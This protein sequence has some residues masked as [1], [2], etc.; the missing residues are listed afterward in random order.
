VHWHP[1][2]FSY[3]W[4]Y[5]SCL[6]RIQSAIG[7][8]FLCNSVSR[9]SVHKTPLLLNRFLLFT[10]NSIEAVDHMNRPVTVDIINSCSIVARVSGTIERCWNVRLGR[11]RGLSGCRVGSVGSVVPKHPPQHLYI[12]TGC[13]FRITEDLNQFYWFISYPIFYFSIVQCW[14]WPL[15][16]NKR[17]HYV[18][19]CAPGSRQSSLLENGNLDI[20]Y[21]HF[22]KIFHKV[23]QKI[24]RFPNNASTGR[25]STQ[26]HDKP[27]FS[28]PS[29]NMDSDADTT[30]I[31]WI[32]P[33]GGLEKT[34]V[35]LVGIRRGV[36]HHK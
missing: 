4:S 3:V 20:S 26:S 32:R 9:G 1:F 5:A 31:R 28:M 2:A 11:L 22:I 35:I 21:Y 30:P 29:G 8:A 19:K 10:Y 13:C 7:K 6:R 27:W 12:N 18:V 24:I 36:Y 34:R 25:E 33:S 16:L 23:G 17:S 15:Y 14:P